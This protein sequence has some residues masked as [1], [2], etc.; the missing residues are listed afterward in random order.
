MTRAARLADLY[1]RSKSKAIN[2]EFEINPDENDGLNYA[3]DAV[4]RN[5]EE[6]RKMH[7]GDCE[8]CREVIFLFPSHLLG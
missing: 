7:G 1:S 6:R 2:A 3:Y 8:C 5:K 4:V